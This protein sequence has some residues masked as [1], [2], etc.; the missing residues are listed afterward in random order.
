MD[1][2]SGA[3]SSGYCQTEMKPEIDKAEELNTPGGTLLVTCPRCGD[4]A[5]G[6]N[7]LFFG[8]EIL[9]LQCIGHRESRWGMQRDQML[10][11]HQSYHRCPEYGPLDY[12]PS[13]TETA[14]TL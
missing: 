6:I 12:Q 4:K 2:A 10:C 13:H 1:M 7:R 14:I 11:L 3:I 9:L 8:R 5:S